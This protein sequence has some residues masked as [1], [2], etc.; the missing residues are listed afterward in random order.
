MLTSS[1]TLTLTP[2]S[3]VPLTRTC[4]PSVS[5]SSLRLD[6]WEPQ[7]QERFSPVFMFG[8][9]SVTAERGSTP[10]R[11]YPSG[12]FNRLSENPAG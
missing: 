7:M 12:I 11:F 9:F 6:L 10:A 8:R 2:S 3:P 5:S 1:R 4:S